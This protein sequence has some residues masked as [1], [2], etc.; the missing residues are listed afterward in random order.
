MLVEVT[1]Q[2]PEASLEIKALLSDSGVAA[3]LKE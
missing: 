2:R 1:V 3:G